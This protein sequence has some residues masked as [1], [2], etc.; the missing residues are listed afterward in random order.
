MVISAWKR[1]GDFNV[2]TLGAAAVGRLR[3]QPQDGSA[4]L[5]PA[6]TCGGV[7]ARIFAMKITTLQTPEGCARFQGTHAAPVAG[8]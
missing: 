4:S 6:A 1:A 5:D 8:A 2:V 7:R 3:R